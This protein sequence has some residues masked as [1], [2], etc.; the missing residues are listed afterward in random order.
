M[1]IL[2]K[3]SGPGGWGG[4]KGESL[5]VRRPLRTLWSGGSTGSY[6]TQTSDFDDFT[7]SQPRERRLT[8]DKWIPQRESS[9]SS[10]VWT[11]RQKNQEFYF[12]EKSEIREGQK[13]GRLGEQKRNRRGS[14]LTDD[15]PRHDPFLHPVERNPR[16]EAVARCLKDGISKTD[17]S[18]P[19]SDLL[20]EPILDYSSSVRWST[21][22]SRGD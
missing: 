13:S 12:F 4:G 18:P 2:V 14:V 1:K 21:V 22:S 11:V 16:L 10:Y 15:I 7:P 9:L 5:H 6:T 17:S 20:V 8:L 19:V 3:G